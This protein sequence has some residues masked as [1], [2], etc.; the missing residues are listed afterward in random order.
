MFSNASTSHIIVG[1]NFTFKQW[2]S[3]QTTWWH[4]PYQHYLQDASMIL[5]IQI[6]LL[7]GSKVLWLCSR[8]NNENSSYISVMNFRTLWQWQL[9]SFRCTR[10][11]VNDGQMRLTTWLLILWPKV[12]FWTTLNLENSRTIFLVELFLIRLKLWWATLP[13]ICWL[14]FGCVGSF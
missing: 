3:A 7:H 10:F 14:K 2:Q 4:R 13:W 5:E 9:V 8:A 11:K 12:A 1:S 6:E